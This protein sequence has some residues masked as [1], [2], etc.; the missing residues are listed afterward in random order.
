M[1]CT[2]QQQ[3]E[4][5]SED[6]QQQSELKTRPGKGQ[7]KEQG[8]EQG[9]QA[10]KPKL[11]EALSAEEGQEPSLKVYI[12]QEEQVREMPFEEYVAGV[13]AG[14]IKNDWPVEAIKHKPL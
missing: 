11:P 14:E 1:R 2:A 6:I 5:P 4:K 10:K 7:G 9:E 3:D 8:N 12:V 13:V